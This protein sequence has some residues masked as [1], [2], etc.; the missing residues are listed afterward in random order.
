MKKKITLSVDADLYDQL[1]DVRGKVKISEVV[2]WVLKAM[3]EDVKAGRELS[4]QE[5]REYV[6]S[7]KDGNDFLD[8]YDAHVAPKIE[9]ILNELE[10]IKKVVSRKR[11]K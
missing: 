10:N 7:T 5:L 6:R 3:V 11:K 4:S 8:R 9:K 1:G 2:N